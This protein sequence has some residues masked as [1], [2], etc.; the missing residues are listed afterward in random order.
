MV[1]NSL[2]FGELFSIPTSSMEPTVYLGDHVFMLHS[3]FSGELRRGDVIVIR[4]PIDRKQTFLKR[5][6]GMPGDR[7]QIVNKELRINGVKVSEPYVQHATDYVDS[8]R[9]NFPSEPNITLVLEGI[10]ML[11]SSV[12]NGEVVVPSGSYF[13]MG[14]NRDNSLD[15]RY[16]GFVTKDDL[17]GRPL[18]VLG[19]GKSQFLRYPLGG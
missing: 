16:W 7:I 6:V 3:L 8:Y 2:L 9:D 18:L 4:Y 11:H 17:L 14:D 5:I 10:E 12:K 1:L 13:V 15:S 19:K